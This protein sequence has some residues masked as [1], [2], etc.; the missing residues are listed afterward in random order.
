MAKGQTIRERRSGCPPSAHVLVAMWNEHLVARMLQLVW[1]SYDQLLDE[2]RA[3][4]DWSE[5]YDDI[6]RSINMDL[7]RIIRSRMNS[8]MPIGVQHESWEHETR[9]RTKR[10]ARPRQYDIAFYWHDDPRLMWPLEGKV[11]KSDSDTEFNRSD[12]VETLNTRYLKCDYAPFSNGG[13]MLAYLKTGVGDAVLEH[14]AGRL[15]RCLAPYAGC[16]G[17]CH[18]TS[19]HQRKVPTGKDYPPEFH[20]HHLIMRLDSSSET[21]S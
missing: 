4:F 21:T 8:F 6:E 19:V 12:Y 20:C 5:D 15:G 10:N 1:A 14:I 18:K 3:D 9:S 16:V 2:F 11:L 13:A 7:E 17:R